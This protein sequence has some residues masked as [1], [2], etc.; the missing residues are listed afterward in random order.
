MT[1]QFWPLVKP[2]AIAVGI[3]FGH[4]VPIFMAI[5]GLGPIIERAKDADT[6][7]GAKKSKDSISAPTFFGTSLVGLAIRTYGVSALLNLTGTYTYKGAAYLGTLMF[8]AATLPLVLNAAILEKRPWELIA[9][10]VFGALY[11]MLGLAMVLN[12][13]GTRADSLPLP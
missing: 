9:V 2:S 6:P 3:V 1:I 5:P 4:S 13:W 7:E 10:K 12:W 8:F 11:E